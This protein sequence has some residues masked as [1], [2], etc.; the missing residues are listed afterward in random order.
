MITEP[1]FQS[2]IMGGVECSTHRLPSGRRLDM[3]A[4]TQHDRFVR[5]DYAR[6]QSIGIKT[7][8][9]GFR[10]HLIETRPG[11]YD[12]SSVAE[13]VRAA[14][15]MGIQVIWDLCHYGYPDDID[16]FRP[17]LVNRFEAYARAATE[18]LINETD[19]APFFC[20]MNEISFFSWAGGE[21]AHL[22]PYC[23]HRGFE[24]KVQLARAAI[25]GT[26]A[27]WSV[28]PHARIVHVDPIINIIADPDRP[29][30]GPIAHGHHWA[31]HQG[32]DLLTGRIWPQIGGDPKYLDI[33]GV[34]YYPN[35]QWIYEG[36]ALHHRDPLYRPFRDML[37]DMYNRYQRPIFVAE[38]GTEG[39]HRRDWLNYV[40][41]EIRAAM[42]MGVPM[43]GMCLYPIFNHP[44]WLDDRHCHNGLWDYADDNGER[45]LCEP[46]AEEIAI[47]RANFESMLT[48]DYSH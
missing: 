34:N 15:D 24:L 3:I 4:A 14:R 40:S 10:W 9:S 35:N 2:F 20:P 42:E 1:L 21:G 8:R 48:P 44:G 11:H 5:Q 33:M 38:T 7:I 29:E 37:Y 13:Q 17:E 36:R 22:N 41:T 47:Q 23:H 39:D 18:W 16:I 32:W 6:F 43:E 12:F 46:L 25:A 19:A 31:Q 28:A 26:E 45:E 30:E 27:I